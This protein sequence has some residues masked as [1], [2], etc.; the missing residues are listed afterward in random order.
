MVP[1]HQDKGDE[2]KAAH[3]SLSNGVDGAFTDQSGLLF[4]K[5]PLEL[6][7]EIYAF[8]LG[9]QTFRLISVPWKVTTAADVDGNVSMTQA[10]F[11]PTRPTVS[12][13]SHQG[14]ALLQTCRQIYDESIALLYSTNTFIIH[15]FA[16]MTTF[17]KTVPA[18][19]L[20]EIRR[21]EVNYS[22]VTSIP[23]DH[24]RTKQYDLPKGPDW[25]DFW[26]LVASMEGLRTLHVHL[27]RYT[28]L[29]PED[30]RERGVCE[31]RTLQPLT[32]LRGLSDFSLM[33]GYL[34]QGRRSNVDLTVYAPMFREGLIR[35]ATRPREPI[36]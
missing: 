19:H 8:V 7:R 34:P 25:A 10:H 18:C 14:I 21:L 15:D 24:P 17:A 23:Y 36:A 12:S 6:R 30:V 16:S 11:E 27:E 31:M 22:P 1:A 2:P 4:E 28:E 26:D 13:S 35:S 5:L 33:L 20:K 29:V 3:R 32:S 9:R